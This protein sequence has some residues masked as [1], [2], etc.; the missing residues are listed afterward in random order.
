MGKCANKRV[1]GIMFIVSQ[2]C[3][4]NFVPS[5]VIFSEGV[6]NSHEDRSQRWGKSPCIANIFHFRTQT[7]SFVLGKSRDSC[8][9][10]W[11]CLFSIRKSTPPL[12]VGIAPF[13]MLLGSWATQTSY[14]PCLHCFPCTI[15]LFF[16]GVDDIARPRC[17]CD[18][19][20]KLAMKAL[21]MPWCSAG[22][23]NNGNFQ[24][25]TIS[26]ETYT[27]DHLPK[28]FIYGLGVQDFTTRS[29]RFADTWYHKQATSGVSSD[30]Y[31][32]ISHG[33]VQGMGSPSDPPKQ[34][35]HA[36]DDNAD[37]ELGFCIREVLCGAAMVQTHR[38]C[39]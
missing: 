18:T 30:E 28:L 17:C 8:L 37:G 10:R 5:S 3:A 36:S 23:E 2:H 11:K 15:L 27:K 39:A 34:V 22:N 7:V 29:P 25:S 19:N 35:G 32:K 4:A 31:D 38:S 16:G 33:D 21:F 14:A 1:F 13:F 26:S 20:M 9:R 12:K 6:K 24:Q